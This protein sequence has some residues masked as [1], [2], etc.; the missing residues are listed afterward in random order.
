MPDR[1]Q[2]EVFVDIHGL[3]EDLNDD[4]LVTRIKRHVSGVLVGAFEDVDVINVTLASDY[5]QPQEWEDVVEPATP[6][7]EL[8]EESQS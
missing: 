2:V 7:V 5:T 3:G 6:P 8:N 1:R 4:L